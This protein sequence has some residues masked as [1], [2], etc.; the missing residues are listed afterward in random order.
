[1]CVITEIFLSVHR[2]YDEKRDNLENGKTCSSTFVEK[3]AK[4]RRKKKINLEGKKKQGN[5]KISRKKYSKKIDVKKERL[6]E[7]Q[8]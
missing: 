1:M 6:R 5:M 3:A 8:D 4:M 7:R 2:T